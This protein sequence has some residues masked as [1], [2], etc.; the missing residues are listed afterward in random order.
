MKKI[1]LFAL[2]LT[3]FFITHI[4][5]AQV[6]VNQAICDPPTVGIQ[7]PTPACQ[8]TT[9]TLTAITS[10][11]QTSD[12][13]GSY[14]IGFWS[15]L[16]TNADGSVNTTSAPAS[17]AITS[18]DNTS[19]ASGDTN[20]T[21]IVPATGTISFSWSY[22]SVDGAEY[23]YP[24]VIVNGVTTLFSGYDLLGASNQSGTMSVNVTAGQ[25][26]SFNMHTFDNNFGP[27]TLII[28]NFVATQSPQ[29]QW[30]ATN[31]GTITGFS[32][33]LS[34]A[35]TTSG[36]YT[37]TA[38]NGLCSASD[39]VD[40]TFTPTTTDGSVTTSI[41]D[42]E[43]YIWPANGQS[44]TAS[45][46][47]ITHVDGCN[48]ATLNL[49][50]TPA[51]TDGSVTT[52][53]CQGVTYVWPANGLSYTTNQT[54][55]THIAGCNIA[56]LN[57]TVSP[58]TTNGSVTQSQC[59]GSYIWPLP[60]GTGLSYSTNQTNLINVVG[61]NTATLNLI[62][63]GITTPLTINQTG[64]TTSCDPQTV[65]LCASEPARN[66][67]IYA[68]TAFGATN[69]I[70]RFT[71]NFTTH[72]LVRDNTYTG[73][74][75]GNNYAID[76]NPLTGEVFIIKDS[77]GR[78]LFSI[79]L[80][81]N[82]MVD[83]GLVLSTLGNNQVVDF[84]FDNNGIMYAAFNNGT[85]QR[86]N[87][88]V[89]GLTPTAFAVGLPTG[90]AGLTYDFDANRL[91]YASGVVT[92]SLH[93]INSLGVVSF[94]YNFSRAGANSAQGIEYVGNN[95][96]YASS[97]G[98]SDIIYRLNMLT[99][100]TTTILNPTLF[101]TNVKDLMYV[102][103]VSL[104][105]SDS[106][107]NLGTTN[108]IDVTPTI[109]SSYNLTMTNDYGCTKLATH[110]VNVGLGV[111]TTN[112]SVT[113]TQCG[114]TYTWPLP[115]GTGLTYSSSQNITNTVGC[116]TA[117]LNLTITPNTTLGSVTTSSQTAY[118]WQLPYGTGQIYTTN[119]TGLTN[120]VGCNTATLNLTITGVVTPVTTFTIGQSCG[121]TTTNLA[122]TI[123]TPQ[124]AGA[125]SYTFRLRN[126]VTLAPAQEIVRPVN[127]FALSNYSGITLGT[128]YQ[129]EV[130]V[131][132][133]PFGPPCLVITPTP[134][135]NIG[136]QCG[137]TLNSMGQWVYATY[138]PNVKGYKFRVTNT[139]TNGIQ[140]YES[141]L[142]RFSFN[143]LADRAFATVYFVEVALKNTDNT[144]LPYS[145]G[146]NIT[147]PSF[148]ITNIRPTQCGLATPT[149]SNVNLEAVIV[150]AA[151]EYR[152]KVSNA[153]QPY[154]AT[155]DR[156]IN[157]AILSM[158]PGLF[159]NTTYDVQVALK[160]NGV[161]GPYGAG[162]AVK[163]PG[164]TKGNE[165][166]ID[167]FKVIAYP[168]PF[169]ENFMF[170]VKTISET[171]IQIKVYDMLGK[172]IESRN[173]EV[174]DV[175][176]LQIGANYPSGVYN[177][178]VLQGENAKTIRVIKR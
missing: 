145:T 130:S 158:F 121:A 159:P 52:T 22:S 107:G 20:Y 82:I 39:S 126:M 166:I 43:T 38:S 74:N 106:S 137:T 164:L 18:G 129:I 2:L 17:I 12:F 97:T 113:R 95:T 42:G 64:N 58:A 161:W 142:N 29:L 162:C 84:T 123:N 177:V 101:N 133:G 170:D 109:T 78:R 103:G 80:A 36:T 174:T 19:D 151:T 71:P 3:S 167:E 87:Y 146:C 149:S 48:T 1:T 31:G 27:G 83:K 140:I 104:Q 120:T 33:Q 111:I 55:L 172:Q 67:A 60:F 143:Q 157:K 51:T 14:S 7:S 88:N 176:N 155:V 100:V 134:F 115:F 175:E 25:S 53:I 160:V 28:S 108:C 8:N 57:L 73:P 79:D 65:Q 10:T 99:Q 13:T 132:N 68:I 61:C 23:D 139:V 118:I 171:T 90:A 150:A 6:I 178:I 63:T 89:P 98:A 62:F 59:D 138:V 136:S 168:N 72:T 54:N 165:I 30:V 128:L 76:R 116:N 114:E 44:Y 122:V 70:A 69:S 154:N 156:A 141:E 144:Y 37:L 148:P 26:F 9:K 86:I 32:N 15:F 35:V 75:S 56:T 47:N 135:A 93:Q 4:T 152:F 173:V 124:V 46:T 34:V 117:T 105:W 147:T 11:V 119:Q 85:I 92:M 50:V 81:T 5:V 24:N 21:I 77:S 66:S 112:G 49:T 153:I 40:F 96:C 102:S 94:M 41:C 110:I 91:L 16:N 127:S 163:T 125:V 131:N 169:A 45:Q